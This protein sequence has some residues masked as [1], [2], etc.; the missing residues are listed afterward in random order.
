M[1]QAKQIAATNLVNPDLLTTLRRWWV[2]KYQKPWNSKEFQES[3]REELLI[4]FFEDYYEQNPSE[5]LE[6]L[7]DENGNVVI[8]T[9][10]DIFNKWQMEETLGLTPDF[11]EGRTK[12]DIQ[13][14]KDAFK[15]AKG[16]SVA[17]ES[18]EDVYVVD[19]NDYRAQM[20]RKLEKTKLPNNS[21][22]GDD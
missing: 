5:K 3:T 16:E 10:D 21:F 8:S 7:K 14:E 4:E 2:K 9:E 11:D 19:K 6:A 22:L 15:R 17:D 20:L 13:R 18:I 1:E 12:E